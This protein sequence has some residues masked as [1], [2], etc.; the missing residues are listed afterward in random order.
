MKAIWGNDYDLLSDSC[1][2]RPMCPE[3]EAPIL[4]RD[5]KYHCVCCGNEVDV[6]DEKM[7]EWLKLREETK[8]ETEDC[9]FG[10]KGKNCVRVVYRRN[11][12]TLEWITAYGV[13]TKCNTRFI[14]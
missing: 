13:C 8:V 11:P 7:L 10:C 2:E 5:D 6:T 4:K 12:V 14:V 9:H 3:C 1:F